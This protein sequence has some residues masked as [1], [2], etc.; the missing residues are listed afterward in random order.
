M[1]S[2]VGTFGVFL[3]GPIVKASNGPKEVPVMSPKE[4]M[5]FRSR[6]GSNLLDALLYSMSAGFITVDPNQLLLLDQKYYQKLFP[7]VMMASD[8]MLQKLGTSQ[9]TC[10]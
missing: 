8:V 6:D 10:S 9:D 1:S 5:E 4:L 3:H 7:S 2:Y